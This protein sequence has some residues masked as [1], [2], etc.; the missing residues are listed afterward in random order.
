MSIDTCPTE[1]Q[2]RESD[3]ALY[4][5]DR[6]AEDTLYK[7]KSGT[8]AWAGSYPDRQRYSMDT[9]SFDSGIITDTK[10][11]IM[12][13][14]RDDRT[15]TAR[16]KI[17]TNVAFINDREYKVRAYGR[18]D[19]KITADIIV[20]E[21]W[22]RYDDS[23]ENAEKVGVNQF[24]RAPFQRTYDCG[25]A[26]VTECNQEINP[27]T[28][29]AETQI[30]M[31]SIPSGGEVKCFV[32]DDLTD[33]IEKG[34]IVRYLT[35]GGALCYIEELYDIPSGVFNENP[36]VMRWQNDKPLVYAYY[37]RDNGTYLVDGA[38]S[39]ASTVVD[40]PT[41]SVAKAVIMQVS[42]QYV[43]FVTRGEYDANGG[44]V[45]KCERKVYDSTQTKVYQYNP[46]N[47]SFEKKSLSDIT[48][49]GESKFENSEAVVITKNR[50][51]LGI[52]IY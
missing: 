17:V 27:N 1:N 34:Q 32:D 14:P 3:Y 7:I 47:D 24:A 38:T 37:L 51:A 39:E 10:T 23:V 42:G 45:P 50:R 30:T 6:E 48:T 15:N 18:D 20:Y 25:T 43:S 26:I 49:Y 22:S 5:S 52:I 9:K 8:S 2:D 12:A 11:I 40:N 16:Y 31:I 44:D 33:G 4:M 36:R 29:C 13:V 28:E 21:Y 41:Y 46:R 19:D 35:L